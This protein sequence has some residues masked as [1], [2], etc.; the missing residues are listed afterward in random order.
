M[1]VGDMVKMSHARG[2]WVGWVVE[3]L[4]DPWVIVWKP[5]QGFQTWRMDKPLGGYH[6]IEVINNG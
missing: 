4:E 6:K 2:H 1:K 5:E 3:L